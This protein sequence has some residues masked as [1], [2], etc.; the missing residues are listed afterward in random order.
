V[1]SL[2]D[3]TRAKALLRARLCY[4]HLA[5]RLGVALMDALLDRGVLAADGSPETYRL[6]AVGHE[7]LAAFGVEVERLPHRRS[8]VRYCIDWGEH[9]HHLAGALGAAVT[10]RMFVLGWLRRGKARRVVHLTDRGRAG[11]DSAFGMSADDL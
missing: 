5:G 8:T 2:R 10:D 6:T 4:D 9:R 7:R 3:D 11:M 1:R